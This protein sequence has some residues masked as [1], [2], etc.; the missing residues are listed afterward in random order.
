MNESVRPDPLWTPSEATVANSRIT[1]FQ[2]YVAHQADKQFSTYEELWQWSTSELDQFW[3]LVWDFFGL[4][5]MYGDHGTVLE[6]E[7]MPG[8]SWFPGVSV[9]YTEY[10]LSHGREQEVAMIGVGERGE[11]T[12]WTWSQLRDQVA[13]L[14]QWLRD[15]G[16]QRGDRVVGYLPNVPE[17]VVAML[18][19]AGIGA[20]W[21]SVGQD[22]AA[23]AVADRFGPL[24]AKV[25]VTAD[26]YVFAGRTHDRRD[27]IRDVVS[28][29]PTVADVLVVNRL[30][31]GGFDAPDVEVHPWAEATT[32]KRL[33]VWQRVGFD[34][35]LWVLFSSGTTGPP[36][37]IVQSHG[38][39]L[40][41]HL[42]ALGLHFDI[43]PE[44]R[45]FWYTS[46]SWM[47]WN[48]NTSGLVTGAS[49]VCYDGA[50]SYPDARR[51]WQLAAEHQVTMFGS[52]P[53][54]L[55]SSKQTGIEP[56]RD[57]DISALRVLATTGAPINPTTHQWAVT[58]TGGLP[59]HSSS[60]GTDICGAF[61]GGVPT[62]PIWL[63]ELSVRCLGVA[64]DAWDSAGNSLREELG[65]LVM[66]RPLPSM[67]IYFWND[68][69]GKQYREAYFD[70]YPGVWRHGDWITITER[71][72]VV[73]HGRSD[74]TLNR[75][76]IRMGSAD[77]YNAVEGL[78]EVSESLVL[79]VEDP[80]GGYW[81]P[82]FIVLADSDRQ[83]DEDLRERIRDVIRRDVS[84]SHVPDEIIQV[85][86][87][88]H[89]RTGK[90]LEVPL[91]R[92]M[93]GA[94]SNTVVQPTALDDP[95][96]LEPFLELARQRSPQR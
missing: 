25:L 60:G 20:I 63:G 30:A 8:A 77:I 86:G 32:G 76:G 82:L 74:A 39:I 50:P 36:K 57:L 89:T 54:Y 41:E 56:A 92:M 5:E 51:L 17:A 40:L 12:E 24:E 44:D 34:E 15:R 31:D 95:T 11:A 69:D 71:N 10:V 3:G 35:A 68:P 49:I 29:L 53:G 91:K 55:D 23:S 80:D 38:G 47:M 73:I 4:A 6:T 27:T 78:D 81:M 59:L 66:T 13:A 45:L 65:E 1:A 7:A 72:S 94:D 75:H 28:S 85:R 61:C 70:V 87:L 46:P 9:N 21:A 67:P 37:G 42:V 52:S 26:S 79:G 33:P 48:I 2:E 19:T 64:M 88:P 16:V 18:A 14:A 58:A 93:Q 84:R 43:G 22:Y 83:L 62:V 96:L 90:R